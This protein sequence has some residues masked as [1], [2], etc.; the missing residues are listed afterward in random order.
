MK[1]TKG[2]CPKP[3]GMRWLSGAVVGG[4][5]DV[6][7]VQAV[8]VTSSVLQVQVHEA[9]A[10]AAAAPWAQAGGRRAPP[11]GVVWEVGGLAAPPLPARAP[12]WPSRAPPSPPPVPPAAS[13]ATR[14]LKLF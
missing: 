10:A 6:V 7:Q 5:R 2:A 14:R 4:R 13:R 12:P 11:R 9:A 1:R 8:R 3:P